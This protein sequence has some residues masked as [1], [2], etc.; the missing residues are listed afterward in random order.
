[1]RGSNRSTSRDRRALRRK[2]RRQGCALSDRRT[3]KVNNRS[4]ESQVL[5]V[6]RLRPSISGRKQRTTEQLLRNFNTYSTM[7]VRTCDGYKFPVSFS[8]KR[9]S[10]ESDS[11]ACSNL[12]P[13][14]DM[15]L[16]YRKTA[17]DSEE[18]LISARTNLPYTALP[19]AFAFQR[20][21]NAQCSCNYALLTPKQKPGQNANGDLPV[22]SKEITLSRTPVPVYR[23]RWADQAKKAAQERA[24]L[25]AEAVELHTERK[26]AE[27]RG[28]RVVGDAFFPNQ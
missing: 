22:G 11:Q 14:T 15:E 16:F 2:M 24:R 23:D 5:G 20:S 6:T 3:A 4:I 12:C 10:F 27:N 18:N 25:R 21:F 7:C 17:G 8:T 1:M 28:V 13:G 26:V 9:R 19:N